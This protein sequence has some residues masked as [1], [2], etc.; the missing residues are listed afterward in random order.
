MY[1]SEI[2]L[3]NYRV[4]FGLQNIS[5]PKKDSKNVFI[6]SGNNGFGKTSLLNSL[7]WCLYGKQ[8]I[9]VDD[10]FK[11]EIYDAGG[12]KKYAK[13]NLNKLAQSRGEDE[14]SVAITL[15]DISIPSLFCNNL[16]ITRTFNASKES[17]EI[18][19]LIDGME[20]ELT[21]EV[22][23]D[24]FISDFILPKEVAKFF[25]F[26]AEKIVS[27]A[28]IKSVADKRK[29]STAYSEVLGIKK[30]EDLKE[31]LEEV[32]IRLRKESPSSADR[33][34]YTSL[35]KDISRTKELITEYEEQIE[36]LNEEKETKRSSSEHYQEK[37]IREGNSLTLDDLKQLKKKRDTLKKEYES[38]KMQLRDMLELAPFAIAGN[39]FDATREQ[40]ISEVD[41]DKKQFKPAIIKSN[42]KKIKS[43][44]KKKYKTLR[45]AST[46]QDA[47]SNLVESQINHLFGEDSNNKSAKVLLD[48]TE[49]ERNEFEAIYNNLKYSY[50]PTFKEITKKHKANRITY[51]KV[52]RAITDAEAKEDDLLIRE[53]R[54]Q[55]TEID[56]QIEGIDQKI[57]NLSIEVGMLQKELANKSA[58]ASTLG[59]KI[60]VHD[61][62]KE[63][64]DTAYR[65][66]EELNTFI[67]QLK[68]QK[69]SSLEQRIKQT[70]NSLM[71]KK[72]FVSRVEVEISSGMI[73][74]H[75]YDKSKNPIAK[76]SLSKGEQQLY[77]TSLLKSLVD[78][79][80]IQFPI[81]IDSPLQKFDK[82]HAK[83]IIVEFYPGISSQVVLFPLLEKEL[84]KIEYQHLLP[85][86]NK[87]YLIDNKEEYYSEII[88]TNSKDLFSNAQEIYEYV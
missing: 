64:D 10:K 78:E 39:I 61:L 66:I 60:E 58:M 43:E 23:H 45:L 53:I 88:E 67:N 65:L 37:L 21:R 20:N 84:S 77:A 36:L 8:M 73:D 42:I 17:E 74:I 28:E 3:N 9:D 14:Y 6:I 7:L 22:G 44:L 52:I 48:F 35:Q 57:I 68:K 71:H 13:S 62:D 31:N 55:K 15:T 19:I 51:S 63:K 12:Y 1:I 83:N 50:T 69:K 30:Y 75:L 59:K 4:Y 16:K 79:S 40:M 27:L 5:F 86:V 41:S 85:K 24:I 18:S 81:F 26:D 25:F 33:K 49:N 70:L 29:L 76:E 47:L 87:A 82:K 46:T 11:S 72:A 32:R 80:N 34:K 54:Q 56:K 38:L 2:S